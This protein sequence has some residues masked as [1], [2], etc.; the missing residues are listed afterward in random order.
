MTVVPTNWVLADSIVAIGSG[1][2]NL[3]PGVF[4]M[5]SDLRCD[6]CD[7]KNVSYATC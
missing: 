4:Q 1:E 2:A 3:I 6:L 7:Q 5:I